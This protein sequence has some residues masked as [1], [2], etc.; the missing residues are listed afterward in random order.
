MLLYV[1][2]NLIPN[3]DIEILE[4]GQLVR[5]NYQG[6]CAVGFPG[7]QSDYALTMEVSGQDNS[8]KWEAQLTKESIIVWTLK[9]KS[10]L[11]PFTKGR[12]SPLWKR[13]VRGDFQKN[14]SNQLWTP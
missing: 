12:N 2:Q 4:N 14:M 9:T 10:L 11:P 6:K 13:G 7:F 3:G 8:T 1:G 5:W